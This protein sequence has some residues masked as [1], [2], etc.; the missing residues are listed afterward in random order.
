MLNGSRYLLLKKYVHGI[1]QRHQNQD[2]IPD[3]DT[4]S[5]DLSRRKGKHV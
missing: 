4:N 3:N 2:K 1:E 5:Q